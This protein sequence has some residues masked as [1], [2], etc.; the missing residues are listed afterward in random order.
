MPNSDPTLSSAPLQVV[1]MGVS[2]SGKSIVGTALA[3]RLGWD[4]V[5]GDDLHPRANVAKME[6][7]EPLTD[8][9]RAPWLDEVNASARR[10]HE[11]RRSSVL[12][13]SALKRSY[14]DRLRDGVPAMLFLHLHGPYEV[15][16]PRMQRRERHFMPTTL[17]RSQFDTLE[18]LQ[19][20]EDGVVVDISGTIDE[21]TATAE[22]EIAARLRR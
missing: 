15:L 12:T 19:P 14:R 18:L 6:A 9:D 8:E 11:A 22:S 1:V 2:G 20:D 3:D 10:Q 4:F 21:V 13:C 17:L 7:G 16:E 5:E